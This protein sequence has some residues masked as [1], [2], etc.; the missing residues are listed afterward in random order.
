MVIRRPFPGLT[1][2]LWGE[3]ERYG[4]DYWSRIPGAYSTGDAARIDTDGYAW[5]MGRADEIIKIAGHRLGTIE[6]ETAFLRH[7]AVAEAGATGRPDELRGEVIA[8]FVVLKHGRHPSDALRR[9][10][11]AT[12]REELGAV[13]GRLTVEITRVM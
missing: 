13:A 1:A 8:A 5:F 10:L 11:L 4:A 3:P 12:V 7:P 6:V 2:S 9:E